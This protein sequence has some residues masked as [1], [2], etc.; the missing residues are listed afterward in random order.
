S[1]DAGLALAKFF[2]NFK[3]ET[4]LP[5]HSFILNCRI[6]RAQTLLDGGRHSI[7]AIAGMLR[8]SSRQHFSTVF[9]RTLGTTPARYRRNT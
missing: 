8:F 1:R 6:R 2:E 7:D 9:K 5:P 3:R 4:G